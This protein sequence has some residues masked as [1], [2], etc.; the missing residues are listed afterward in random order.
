MKG[1]IFNVTQMIHLSRP[2]GGHRIAHYLRDLGWDIEVVDWANHWTFEELKEFAKSRHSKNLK[3]IGFSQLFSHWDD[4]LENFGMWFKLTY[5]DVPILCGSSVNPMY[6]T[7]VVDYYFQGFSEK[8]LLVL[9][10]YLY[11][12]GDK[13]KLKFGNK[14]IISSYPLESLM[15]K[16]EDRDFIKPDEWL[17][18]EFSRGCKFQCSYCNFPVLGVKGD[19]SRTQEDFEEQVQDA[20]DRFGCTNYLV[21]DETFNDR[22]EKIKKFA[23][24][25]QRL[26]FETWFTGYIR[27]DL[28][29]S[30]EE[31]KE[32]LLRMNFLGHYYGIESFNHQSAKT[33]G[34]GLKSEKLKQGLIDV[35]KYFQ[36]N[37]SNR[38]RGHISLICGLPHETKESTFNSF[39][40]C[41]ENW[42]DQGFSMF[43]LLVPK[44]NGLNN[45]SKFTTEFNKYG[46]ELLEEE[47]IDDTR[48]LT[49][50][51]SVAKGVRQLVVEME[52]W[53]NKDMNIYDAV[54]TVTEIYKERDKVKFKPGPWALGYR[55]TQNVTVN[56]RLKLDFTRLDALLD[57]K[58]ENYKMKK[59][60]V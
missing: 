24:V 2:L 37:N 55:L 42:Y 54:E 60:G 45:V 15:V 14:K 32:Q 38:Y 19:Y 21:S 7:D 30:R 31:D 52:L 25:V 20:Y 5:P 9:L 44:N 49:V 35:K 50:D 6:N 22:T 13:P 58:I 3:F 47:E 59:L 29:V 39:N 28:L 12:N 36:S 53:K 57:D 34:K 8:A 16:Y 26:N 56:D 11:G 27:A 10:K 46:Y 51:G 43:P 41:R 18:V 4:T 33:V 23:D 17:T 40:W 48:P 1:I